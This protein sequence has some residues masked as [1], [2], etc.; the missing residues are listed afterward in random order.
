M[1]STFSFMES[2]FEVATFPWK[3]ENEK[4]PRTLIFV[5]GLAGSRV[6]R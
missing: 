5:L 6:F 4:N 2:K 3:V 1:E